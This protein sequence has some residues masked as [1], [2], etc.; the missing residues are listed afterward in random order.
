MAVDTSIYNLLDTSVPMKGKVADAVGSIQGGILTRAQYDKAKELRETKDVRQKLLDQQVESGE[1]GIKKTEGELATAERI[2]ELQSMYQGV[3]DSEKFVSA[4]DYQGLREYLGGREEALIESDK[5]PSNTQMF[6][7][8]IEEEM[9]YGAVDPSRSEVIMG[10]LAQDKA[11]ILEELEVLQGT[12]GQSAEARFYGQLTQDLTPEEQD[13]ARRIKLGLDPR[14]VGSASI[15]IAET[16][17]M[18]ETVGA[19][20]ADIAGKKSKATSKEAEIG[21]AEGEAETLPKRLETT[22]AEAEQTRKDSAAKIKQ[23]AIAKDYA[24][25]ESKLREA[26]S[27]MPALKTVISDLTEFE[28]ATYTIGGKAYDVVKRELGGEPREAAIQRTRML[29]TINNQVL[30]QLKRMLGAAFTAKEAEKVLELYGSPDSH[31]QER[32]AAL[33]SLLRASEIEYQR[34]QDKMKSFTPKEKNAAN[35]AKRKKLEELRAR[36]AN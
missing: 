8:Q 22:A 25:T 6:K 19:S 26:E 21:K 11:A 12:G 1:L 30:P 27:G 24:D 3:I 34:L 31:P 32:K 10:E 23:D 15:T 13:R 33:D 5:D 20:Q 17:G 9:S 7:A 16:P 36:Q 18:T 14:A 29:T 4:N 28:E 2:R 35:D